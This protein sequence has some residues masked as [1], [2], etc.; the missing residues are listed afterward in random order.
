MYSDQPTG[1]I[2]TDEPMQN[3]T[4]TGITWTDVNKKEYLLDMR[5]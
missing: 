3:D 1:I 2:A 5:S 4:A